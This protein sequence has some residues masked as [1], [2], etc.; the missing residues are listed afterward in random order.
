MYP[1]PY[2]TMSIKP[3]FVFCHIFNIRFAIYWVSCLKNRDNRRIQP[4]D[5]LADILEIDPESTF[6]LRTEDISLSY[7]NTFCHIFSP[8]DLALHLCETV[9]DGRHDFG[10]QT[11]R[12]LL[13]INISLI[14]GE[15]Q[16]PYVQAAYLFDL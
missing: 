1:V 12:L 13:F 3:D 2:E 15:D 14:W 16:F 8:V 9:L 4:R 7:H 5:I 10:K 11:L 6:N